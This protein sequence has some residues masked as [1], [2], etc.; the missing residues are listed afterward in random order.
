[1]YEQHT[2]AP[3]YKHRFI[4]AYHGCIIYTYVT[5]SGKVHIPNDLPLYIMQKS[6]RLRGI[7][8]EEKE[9]IIY[10]RCRRSSWTMCWK[11]TWDTRRIGGREHCWNPCRGYI[12]HIRPVSCRNELNFVFLQSVKTKRVCTL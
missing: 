6:M 10:T 9:H 3:A 8:T 2:Y 1:M 4:Y 7:G 12:H 11:S 5:L